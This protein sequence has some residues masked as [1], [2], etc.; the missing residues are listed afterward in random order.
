MPGA[1]LSRWTMSYFAVALV[2]LLAGEVLL[3]AGFGYPVLAVEAPE[4]LVVVHT[5]AIGWL[6]LLFSGALLQFVPVLVAKPLKAPFLA[7]PALVLIVAGLLTLLAG[8]LGLN[9][10]LAVDPLVLPAGGVLLVGGFAALSASIGATIWSARPIGLPAR[11]VAVGLVAMAVTALLGLCITAGLSGLVEDAHV[12]NLI[13][14]GIGLHAAIGL[15]GW[16]TIM[17]MGVSY[18]LLSMFLLSPERDRRTT[19]LIFAVGV[20]ALLLVTI[21]TVLTGIEAPRSLP[22]YAAAAFSFIG[23]GL[24]V[25]DV[26][27]IFRQRRRKTAELNT[28]IS[29][30]AVAFLLLSAMLFAAFALSGTLIENAG[31][32][33]Y[34][35]AMGWLTT[36]G[37]GQLYKIVPFLTWMECYGPVLGKTAV[38]RVQDLVNEKRAVWWFGL[39]IITVGVSALALF[40]QELP[41]FMA[42]GVLQILATVGLMVE[43]ICAR[44]LSCAPPELRLPPGVPRPRLFL[45]IG[46]DNDRKLRGT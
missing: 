37:L 15:I 29:L 31:V 25:Y 4:T 22:L 12:L 41:V 33:V 3:A 7:L 11:F 34:V 5:I 43:F 10:R 42:A 32:L 19:R 16:M 17:A 1:T 39:Y 46:D 14:D 13:L 23:L 21:A 27:C 28:L 24:Y 45:P 36:L 8:F 40:V 26:V 6:G 35:L 30:A 44:R 18:R 38:P 2:F 20:I 9:G